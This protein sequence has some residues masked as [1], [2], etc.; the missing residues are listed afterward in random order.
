MK[1]YAV[2]KGD[3]SAY[4]I[5]TITADKEKAE[6]IAK[7]HAE[8]RFDSCDTRVEEFEDCI[9]V[10]LPLYE[11]SYW[12]NDIKDIERTRECDFPQQFWWWSEEKKKRMK[13]TQK[14]NTVYVSDNNVITL[15]VRAK[16]EEHA[17]KIAYDLIAEYKA[18]NNGIV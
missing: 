4:H 9:E 16:D 1:Y 6:I 11:I 8:E 5:V 2:T 15:W 12:D 18:K 7:L 14:V 10:L 3:Y 13:E 17:R